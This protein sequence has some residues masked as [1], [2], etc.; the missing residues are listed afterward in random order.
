MATNPIKTSDIFKDDGALDALEKKLVR[1]EAAIV[2]IVNIT[3]ELNKQTQSFNVNSNGE[4]FSKTAK[5]TDEAGKAMGKYLKEMSDTRVEIERV[6]LATSELNKLNK[7]SAA[8]KNA[9]F[10]SLNS[11]NAQ[12]K[13]AKQRY[14]QLSEGQKE[15]TKEGKKLDSQIT[16]LTAKI[17]EQKKAQRESIKQR[18][19]EIKANKSAEGSYNQLSARYSLIK[20]QLNA[21]SGASRKFTKEGKALEAQSKAIYKEMDRLQEVTG[22]NQLKVGGYK[23]AIEEA[24]VGLSGFTQKIKIFLK[25]PMIA[26]V[27]LITAG[28]LALGKAFSQ[29]EAGMRIITK[30][31]GFLNGLWVEMISLSSRLVVKI[32]AAFN[33]P[34]QAVKDFG[35]AIVENIINRFEGFVDLLGSAGRA[36]GNL[37]TGNF[38]KFKEEAINAGEAVLQIGTGLDKEAQKKINDGLKSIAKEAKKTADEFKN[39]AEQQRAVKLQNIELA[40]TLGDLEREEAVLA[41]TAGDATLSFKEQEEAAKAQAKA[42]VARY[43][44]ELRIANSNL[45]LI[46]DEIK[47]RRS[48]G[49]ILDTLLEQELGFIQA[50]KQAETDLLLA[51]KSNQTEQRQLVQDRLERD[52]DILLDIF[53]NQKTINEKTINNEKETI[54]KRTALLDETKTLGK[55]SFDAQIKTIQEFTALSIDANELITESDAKILNAKIRS[56]GLSEIIEG[57][58]LEV[59][60]DRKS[61]ISDLAEAEEKLYQVRAAIL[62][63]QEGK[64]AEDFEDGQEAADNYIQSLNSIVEGVEPKTFWDFIGVKPDSVGDFK[65]ELKGALDFAKGQLFEYAALRTQLADQQVQNSERVVGELQNEL[66]IELQ[67]ASLGYAANVERVQK[68][69][70]LQKNAQA[71]ALENRKKAQQQELALQTIEQAVNLATASTKLWSEF[72]VAAIPLIAL[73]FGSFIGAKAKAFQL[74]KQEFGEGGYEKIGGG[75]HASGN[76]TFLGFTT[77]EGKA[78]FGQKGESHAIFNDKAVSKYGEHLPGLVESVNKLTYEGFMNNAGQLSNESDMMQGGADMTTTEQELKKI[79]RQGERKYTSTGEMVIERYKSLTRY[80]R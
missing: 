65:D 71:E 16:R 41:Q 29:S 79:R 38:K 25:S 9:E 28:L 76:D 73:M 6:K 43:A 72:G 54:E 27:S 62:Q 14:D 44:I 66:Q 69:L 35:K 5:E 15:S 1:I 11:F 51:T 31:T 45:S 37:L 50:Q 2:G 57:R 42:I 47:L 60:R 56:Y 80:I 36:I 70:A 46:R 58:L 64:I 74:A 13:L 8:I 53:D 23:D 63:A 68:E 32:K 78:A 61:A 39:L 55:D 19:L 30:V 3:K 75:S 17:N 21:M 22:K 12:L 10:K 4:A 18:E 49:Q 33:D 52:L 67:K 48:K 77:N 26:I 7:T 20:V 34:K 40:K 59:I 24:G